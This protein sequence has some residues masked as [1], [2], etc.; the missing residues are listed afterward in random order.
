VGLG[1]IF[2]ALRFF[3]HSVVTRQSLLGF[4]AKVVGVWGRKWSE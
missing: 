4:G 3:S 1:P 2:L